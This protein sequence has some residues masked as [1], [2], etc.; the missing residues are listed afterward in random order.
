MKQAVSELTIVKKV[1]I[2]YLRE[3]MDPEQIARAEFSTLARKAG[4]M[5]QSGELVLK[6]DEPTPRNVAV[7]AGARF[8]M[9]D[10]VGLRL[11]LQERL[12]EGS[13]LD[14]F[15]CLAKYRQRIGPLIEAAS[16][17]AQNLRVTLANSVNHQ[18]SFENPDFYPYGAQ[19]RTLATTLGSLGLL[20]SPEGM[21]P[22]IV[23]AVQT[24]EEGAKPDISGL[25]PDDV[26]YGVRWVA[27]E[28]PA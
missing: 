2:G 23:A 18:K 25:N 14:I 7:Q 21:R 8:L 27:E 17:E 10:I 9:K 12:S 16:L 19:R 15:G 1:G 26:V 13:V 6:G 3:E 22:E 5:L 4:R 11:T 20:N 28:Q 24:P